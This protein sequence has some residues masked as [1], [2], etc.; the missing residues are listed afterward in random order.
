[1]ED[2]RSAF[3]LTI[4]GVPLGDLKGIKRRPWRYKD[5]T[6]AQLSFMNKNTQIFYTYQAKE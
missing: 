1:M 4:T 5:V 3:R 2:T 6:I